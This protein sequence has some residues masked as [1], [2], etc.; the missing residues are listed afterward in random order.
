MVSLRAGSDRRGDSH[1]PIIAGAI[2][3]ACHTLVPAYTRVSEA[4]QPSFGPQS[5]AYAVGAVAGRASPSEDRHPYEYSNP[6]TLATQ[7]QTQAAMTSVH[8]SQYA[9]WAYGYWNAPADTRGYNEAGQ[10]L[11]TYADPA[12][13]YAF[14]E[15]AQTPD[16]QSPLPLPVQDIMRPPAKARRTSPSGSIR[17]HKGSIQPPAGIAECFSC[18]TRSSPEW[19]RGASGKK[20]LC[21]ACVLTRPPRPRCM[22]TR[23]HSCGLRYSRQRAKSQGA[24]SQRR[25]KPPTPMDGVLTPPGLLDAGRRGSAPEASSAL[26]SPFG[27]YAPSSASSQTTSPSPSP[28]AHALDFGGHY[29]Y[30]PPSSGLPYAANGTPAHDY[31][32]YYAPAPHTL[33]RMGVPADEYAFAHRADGL[34]GPG[35]AGAYA[36]AAPSSYERLRHEAHAA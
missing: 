35:A 32:A 5:L 12:T 11:Y 13:A 10:Q 2:I 23:T 7:V 15:V 19:R 28:P 6:A 3:F 33:P 14:P 22:L 25:K 1:T 20:D 27:G 34:T 18:G 4:P 8:G 31:G 21:N 9:P 36:Y 24:A 17:E 30:G 29:A 26:S 16:R